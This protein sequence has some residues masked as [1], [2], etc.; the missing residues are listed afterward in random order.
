MT[1]AL[2]ISGYEIKEVNGLYSLNDFHKASGNHPKHRP[3]Q[4]IRIE[5]TKSLIKEISNAQI[6]AIKTVRGQH[7][8][9]YACREL[10]IAYAA[11]ISPAFHLKV[12]RVFLAETDP[13]KQEKPKTGKYHYPKQLLKQP[14]FTGDSGELYG[15]QLTHPR[16]YSPLAD[17]L[18]RLEQDNND[19]EACK[20]EYAA[21][22]KVLGAY[23]YFF[24]S[25][26]CQMLAV[27]T[28]R[29]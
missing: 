25:M 7:G 15:T 6:C 21:M 17:L 28:E 26:Q 11:W 29:Y 8:G 12:I 10:V 5:Q 2:I 14:Y 24:E 27:R 18:H 22:K 1:N 9:T 19:V 3:N 4:F 16:F 13:V 23:N 20:N